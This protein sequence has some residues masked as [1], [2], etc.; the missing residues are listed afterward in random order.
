MNIAIAL[1]HE[2]PF[3][4]WHLFFAMTLAWTSIVLHGVH[5]IICAREGICIS[6]LGKVWS[7]IAFL[8]VATPYG[9]A[10]FFATN[11]VLL[12]TAP[13]VAAVGA[14]VYSSLVFLLWWKVTLPKPSG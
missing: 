7:G 9:I 6:R 11:I 13:V 1:G 2:M 8:T 10:F 4:P 5:S 3:E 14:I 12:G